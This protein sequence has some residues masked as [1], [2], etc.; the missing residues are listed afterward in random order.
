MLPFARKSVL[1]L[2]STLQSVLE[3]L[4]WLISRSCFSVGVCAEVGAG[5]GVNAA[6][7]AGK[8]PL[9]LESEL[10]WCCLLR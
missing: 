2:E 9:V 8:A 1:K 4:N 10:C 3:K 6:V 5:D 7:G